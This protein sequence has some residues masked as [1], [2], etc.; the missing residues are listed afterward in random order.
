MAETE[1]NWPYERI[2]KL[3]HPPEP[4]WDCPTGECNC[5]A[6]KEGDEGWEFSVMLCEPD[7]KRMPGARCRVVINGMLANEDDPNADGDGWITVTAHHAPTSVLVEW[8]PKDTP[9][10]SPYP[11]RRRYY[12]D[13]REDDDDERARRRLHNLGFSVQPTLREN[14]EDFQLEYEHEK[15]TGEARDIW[16]DLRKYHDEAMVPIRDRESRDRSEYRKAFFAPPG[17]N[18]DAAPGPGGGKAAPQPPPAPPQD[19]GKQ[20]AGQGTV[21]TEVSPDIFMRS[22][23]DVY[24]S[25]DAVF[26]WWGIDVTFKKKPSDPSRQAF[27][28]TFWVFVDALKDK[29]TKLRW[30]CSA[31]ESQI[32]ADKIK[33]SQKDLP[34]WGEPTSED[35]KL[36]CLLMTT[37]LMSARWLVGKAAKEIV[38]PHT[39]DTWDLLIAGS[40]RMNKALDAEV[41]TLGKPSPWVADP[42]KIWA[43]HRRLWDGSTAGAVNYGWHVDPAAVKDGHA[44]GSK[45]EPNA[46]IPGLW[47]IQSAGGRHNAHHLDYSQILLLVAPWCTVTRP[48]EDHSITMKTADVY[49][50]KEFA[51]LVTDDGNPLKDVRQPFDPAE[52]EPARIGFWQEQERIYRDKKRQGKGIMDRI[53]PPKNKAH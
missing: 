50:S 9:K 35:A 17:E 40:R 10:R 38:Q 24:D 42:G 28:G 29:Q 15:L 22:I 30:P 1:P 43:L 25:G 19:K 4:S 12:V 47:L 18:L 44:F 53:P 7:G 8:A 11:H 21:K 45:V 39:D 51:C 46:A 20:K 52:V 27:L 3:E 32:V 31:A 6:V 5:A 36:P 13:L 41:A 33:L 26:E 23:V 49:K 14:V 37:R 34:G 16:D 2:E 48:G